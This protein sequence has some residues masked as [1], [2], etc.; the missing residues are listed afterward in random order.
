MSPP[1]GRE[2]SKS[3]T[4]NAV[5]LSWSASRFL[6]VHR[7]SSPPRPA[8]FSSTI[9]LLLLCFQNPT[10]PASRNSRVFTSIQNPRGGRC[11]A[12]VVQDSQATITGYESQ[13][14]SFHLLADSFSLFAPVFRNRPLCF[15]S[16]ARSFAKSPGWGMWDSHSWLSSDDLASTYGHNQTRTS[17]LLRDTP[18]R[19]ILGASLT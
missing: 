9:D 3:R 12:S 15:Q 11:F 6:R 13:V 16:F 14:T 18:A 19:Y 5:S 2:I 10:N 17:S 8:A 7:P 1:L 4:L